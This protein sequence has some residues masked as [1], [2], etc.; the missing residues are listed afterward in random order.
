MDAEGQ[1]RVKPPGEGG[2]PAAGRGPEVRPAAWSVGGKGAW[3]VALASA[4]WCVVVGLVLAAERSWRYTGPW[5]WLGEALREVRV[6]VTDLDTQWLVTLTLGLYV[7]VFYLW[8]TGWRVGWRERWRS[9]WTW[10]AF[11]L[12]VSAVSYVWSYGRGDHGVAYVA[13]LGG[14]VLGWGMVLWASGGAGAVRPGR[15]LYLMGLLMGWLVLLAT[16]EPGG[17]R[18][19]R[20]REVERWS[21][22]WGHPNDAGL[23]MALAV[24]LAVGWLWAWPAYARWRLREA[25]REGSSSALWKWVAWGWSYGLVVLGI[26]GAGWWKSYSRGAWL[27]AGVGA[28]VLLVRLPRAERSRREAA[29][30]AGWAVALGLVLFGL[31]YWDLRDSEA[32]WVRRIYSVVNAEDFSWRNRVAGW[33]SALRMSADR[34]LLGWGWVSASSVERAFYAHDG[35]AE[36]GAVGLNEY[37]ELAVHGGWPCLALLLVAVV[38]FWSGS[39]QGRD[40][41]AVEGEV[42][43]RVAGLAMAGATVLL[44]GFWF[45]GGLESLRAG[46]WLWML[47]GLGAAAGAGTVGGTGSAPCRGA[48]VVWV[49]TLDLVWG[50]L[51]VW[52]KA[53]DGFDRGRV[54][55]PDGSGGRVAFWLIRPRGAN[56]DLPRVIYVNGPGVEWRVWGPHAVEMASVGMEVGAVTLEQ[57]D[58]QGAASGLGRLRLWMAERGDGENARVV[59]V[60]WGATGAEVLRI[61]AREGWQDPWVWVETGRGQSL[62]D[63]VGD[64]WLKGRWGMLGRGEWVAGGWTG[65]WGEVQMDMVVRDLRKAGADVRGTRVSWVGQEGLDQERLVFRVVGERCVRLWVGEKGWV[66][67]MVGRGSGKRWPWWVMLVPAGIW[68]AGWGWWSRWRGGRWEPRCGSGAVAN[69]RGRLEGVTCWVR[70]TTLGLAGFLGLWHGFHVWLSSRP[71]EERT[72]GLVRARLVMR[73]DRWDFDELLKRVDWRGHP[74][75]VWLEHAHLASYNRRLVNWAVP[76]EEYVR[77]VLDPRLDESDSGAGGWRRWLWERLYPRVRREVA[78][79]RAVGMVTGYLR[80]RVGVAPWGEQEVEKMWRVGWATEAGFARLCVAG[81]RSVGIPAR[82]RGPCVVEYWDGAD[83]REVEPVVA[84]VGER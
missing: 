80:S 23:L 65:A 64:V 49:G 17:G 44:V 18:S 50:G 39:V 70:G 30:L 20:Y 69:E 34:P 33:E 52:A 75:R 71:A 48:C 72:L 74:W 7:L 42:L 79:K 26:C 24:V 31:G 46:T 54:W 47:L 82:L 41:V 68:L 35:P 56:A 11:C 6:T 13:W 27:S 77:W 5:R 36:L 55:L 84:E 29:R 51:V 8:S 22:F 81:L 28:V 58:W 63:V 38:W 21:G 32:P 37:L 45:N 66:P 15:A 10:L 76:D 57:G 1:D 78:I 67:T 16:V 53:G 83:W 12:G 19:Y 59:W 60:G 40:C 4:A 62:G 73:E 25:G 14:V 61:L 9:G 43:R 2:W 3:R